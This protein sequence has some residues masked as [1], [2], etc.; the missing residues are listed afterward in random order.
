MIKHWSPVSLKMGVRSNEAGTFQ[1]WNFFRGPHDISDLLQGHS[2]QGCWIDA[3][4]MQAKAGLK[5]IQNLQFL[6]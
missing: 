6:K 2:V 1:T 4:I 3:E 5:Q